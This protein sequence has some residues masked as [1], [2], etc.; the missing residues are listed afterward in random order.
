MFEIT[1]LKWLPSK[2]IDVFTDQYQWKA[3]TIPEYE[4]QRMVRVLLYS[5]IG[6]IKCPFPDLGIILL[7]TTDI[8]LCGA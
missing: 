7:P 4:E 1:F 2:G 5:C 3:I 6:T 8:K